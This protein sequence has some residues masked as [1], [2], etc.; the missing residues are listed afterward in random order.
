[1][2]KNKHFTPAAST[3]LTTLTL[4][5]M[6]HDTF[7]QSD[8]DAVTVLLDKHGLSATYVV[9]QPV[10][11]DFWH[12]LRHDVPLPVLDDYDMD[13]LT[14]EQ[15]VMIINHYDETTLAVPDGIVPS[16]FIIE[17][18]EM[19]LLVVCRDSPLVTMEEF[20]EGT[21]RKGFEVSLS[22]DPTWAD[23][24]ALLRY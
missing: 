13:D 16:D 24:V 4:C 11:S 17:L 22:T 14:S 21:S 6:L 19:L 2:T 3:G 8:A 15:H 7:E 9:H 5:G 20:V 23:H 12:I 18:A 10:D 1:M